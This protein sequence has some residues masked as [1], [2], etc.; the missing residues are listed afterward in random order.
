MQDTA[1]NPA[2]PL[3]QWFRLEQTAGLGLRYVHVLL[4]AFETPAAIFSAGHQALRA[5]VPDAVAR[6]LCAPPAA[7]PA[8][9]AAQAWMDQPGCHVLGLDDPAYPK[10]LR[11]IADPPLLLFVRG[12]LPLLARPMLAI[13]GS[14]NATGQGRANAHAFAR[15]LSGAGL[16]IVSGLALGIDAAAHEGALAGTGATVAV[17]GTGIDVV[18][19]LRNAALSVRIAEEGCLLSEFML[20]TEPARGHFP[21]RNR[22][23]SGLGSGVLVVEAALGSGSLVTAG[24]ARDQNRDVFAMPGSI[25]APLSK[26]CHQLIREGAKLVDAASDIT[27]EVQDM[28][29]PLDREGASILLRALGHAPASLDALCLRSGRTP[30]F[31]NSQLLALELRGELERLPGGLFQRILH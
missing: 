24:M 31:V 1:P 18:Y 20:G 8:F 15:A 3:D 28:P 27:D 4:D 13:V 12:K 11:Q 26:G 9:A 21:R 14:R 17:L 19:P 22:I 2:T 5:H 16:T 6:A 30:A 25:H 23:I 29:V 10:L 7:D